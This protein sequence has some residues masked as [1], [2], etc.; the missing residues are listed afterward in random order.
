MA[1]GRITNSNSSTPTPRLGLRAAALLLSAF[2]AACTITA[3]REAPVTDRSARPIT[4]PTAVQP[5]AEPAKPPVLRAMP[6]DGNYIVQ[7]GD[8]LF[9]I[10]S[11]FGREVKDLARWNNL[12]D[13]AKIG[14]G[15]SLRVAPPAAETA[16]AMPVT[17]TGPA[18]TRPLEGG[19]AA[20][21]A[22]PP[23]AEAAPAPGPL[24]AIPE[25]RPPMPVPSSDWI[26]P[27]NG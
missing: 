22:T 12:D 10:A 18:T 1:R 24:A 21:A 6:A 20:G 2:L 4:P 14:V 9:S 3:T 15:Q 26:W 11:S 16:A 13:P 19:T 25:S 17:P 23:A 5:P 8:T 7:P 27:A